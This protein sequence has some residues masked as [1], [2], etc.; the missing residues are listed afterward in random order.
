MRIRTKYI[1]VMVAL[2]AAVTVGVSLYLFSVNERLSAQYR[3]KNLQHLEAALKEHARE[4]AASH[5][6]FIAKATEK[7]LL[8]GD[9]E[10]VGYILKSLLDRPETIAATIYTRDG[11]VF[12]DGSE[13]RAW[14]GERGA[15]DV[16]ECI[17]RGEQKIDERP[18]GTIR[19]IAPILMADQIV[20]GL[21]VKVDTD[22]I[23][24]QIADFREELA[25]AARGEFGNQIGNIF[26]V[27]LVALVLAGVVAAILA[28]RL[29][30]PIRELA[31][32]TRRISKGDFSMDVKPRRGDELGELANAFDQMSRKL[33]ETMVSRSEL[34]QTVDEQTHELRE[35]HDS[36]LALESDRREVLLEISEELRAPV[37]E[38]EEDAEHALRNQDSA[39]E[40]RHSM[41]RLLF[42]ICDVRRLVEDLRFASRSDE[43]RLAARRNDKPE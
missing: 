16:V 40:F 31:N 30:A 11:F 3:A 36:L 21:E 38:L 12:H 7:P 25:Q 23:A 37:R 29:S 24:G 35:A 19:I 43:P 20:G 22:F 2:V 28:G 9:V 27:T 32:A 26:G 6:A 14:F 5:A 17:R 13:N 8:A 18:N 42:R 15:D 34:Q 1:L 10:A 41:S 33:R 4:D 39:L